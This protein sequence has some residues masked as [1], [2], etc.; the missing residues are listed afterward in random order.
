MS[1]RTD[2]VQRLRSETFDVIVVGGGINGAAAAAALSAAGA[3]VALIDK[4]D[5]ANQ[6]SSN[7]SNLIWGGIKYLESHEYGLVNKL[8]R[9]R[10]RLLRGC[11]AMVQE[12]RFLATTERGFRKPTWLIQLGAWFY[13]LMGRFATRVPDALTVAEIAARESLI[14]LDDAEGG[15][16]YSDCYLPDGDARFVWHFVRLC[17]SHGGAVANYVESVDA[18]H[19]DENW[20]LDAVDHLTNVSFRIRGKV[21]INACG[22]ELDAYN[23]RLEQPTRNTHAFSRGAHLI[24]PRLTEVKRVLTFF[25]S[26]GRLFFVTPVGSRSCIGTTDTRMDAPVAEITDEDRQFLLDNANELLALDQPLTAADIIAE[27]CGVRPLV[28][29][30]NGG[31]DD[32]LQMSRRHVLEV[33]RL[34]RHI[35]VFGGKLT[36][37]INIGEELVNRVRSLGVVLRMPPRRWFAEP[38][39]DEKAEYLAYAEHSGLDALTDAAA[40]EPLTERLWRRYG[41]DALSIARML[42]RQP[43]AARVLFYGSDFTLGELLYASS[44]EMVT[45]LDDL[46]RR[47]SDLAMTIAADKL[48]DSE[49]LQRINQTFFDNP[50]DYQWQEYYHVL[51]RLCQGIGAINVVTKLPNEPRGPAA[52]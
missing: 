48:E 9:A 24:V 36:D 25:A 51:V 40:A 44:Q 21:L 19:R 1:L 10:N 29:E 8:C 33:D 41:R 45:N 42:E 26:D 17:L 6:A 14:N 3:R 32:W 39:R 4:R 49:L 13:W 5:F 47:R 15:V 22:P 52:A 2:N 18:R 50:P 31:S 30:N 43:G 28:V 35:S 7:S 37:C 38:G 12:I 11:P 16:E 23:A 20:V 27:R 34:A 46:L